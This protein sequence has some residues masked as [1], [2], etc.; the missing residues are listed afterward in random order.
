MIKLQAAKCPQCGADIEVNP[1]L[2]Q[3]I[4]Q[5]CGSCVLIEDAVAKYKIE[6]SGKVKVEGIKS[7]D[8][9]LIQA[10]KHYQIGEFLDARKNLLEII[11][12]DN[13]D[14]EALYELI[15]NDV[16]IIKEKEY[17]PLYL[18]TNPKYDKEYEN[19][20][21]ELSNTYKRIIKIDEEEKYKIVL[22]DYLEKAEKYISLVPNKEAL[23]ELI[24]K[25]N[26]KIKNDEKNAIQD[27]MKDRFY[28]ALREAFQINKN[29]NLTQG[30]II[31]NIEEIYSEGSILLKVFRVNN[32]SNGQFQ[33]EEKEVF[34]EPD[35]YI[36]SYKELEERF[37]KY[38]EF[39]IKQKE[40]LKKKKSQNNLMILIIILAAI[41]WGIILTIFHNVNQEDNNTENGASVGI[42]IKN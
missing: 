16:E 8:D 14:I 40:I 35:S 25:I 32:L 29:M 4:C 12:Q 2:K 23:D 39:Y 41:F 10:K 15:K 38:N 18:E 6:L 22:K 26:N 19:I 17:N 13:F 9:Q 20:F 5:Y 21:L 36:S 33:R 31:S 7:R 1:E 24:K 27:N 11:N 30:Y 37:Q 34:I 28:I 42:V 3:T